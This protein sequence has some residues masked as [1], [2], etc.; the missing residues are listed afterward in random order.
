MTEAVINHFEA[1]KVKKEDRKNLSRITFL[2]FQRMVH[3]VSQERAVRQIRERIMQ[4][5]V[6]QLFFSLF[7]VSDV[8]LGAGHTAYCTAFI[9]DRYSPGEH[10]TISPVFVKQTVL[11]LKM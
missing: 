10:P 6:E 7:S 4:S 2:H 9:A 5:I 3:P 8:C 1:I 11:A